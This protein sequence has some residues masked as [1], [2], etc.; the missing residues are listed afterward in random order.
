MPTV[1]TTV[2]VLMVAGRHSR[3]WPCE[4]ATAVAGNPLGRA[5]VLEDGGHAANFDRPDEFDEAL[6]GFLR[7]L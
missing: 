5:V 1:R 3:Y 2:P 6:L 4:H 7:D